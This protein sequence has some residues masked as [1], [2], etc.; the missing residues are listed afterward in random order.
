MKLEVTQEMIDRSIRRDVFHC[1]I[2][3]CISEAIGK[4]VMV[5]PGYVVSAPSCSM[6]APVVV[7]L[8]VEARNLIRRFDNGKR[9]EPITFDIDI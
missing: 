4:P 2:S 8:P 7:K 1:P 9:V 5:A 3:T 6:V